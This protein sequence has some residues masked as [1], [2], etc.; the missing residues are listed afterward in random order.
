MSEPTKEATAYALDEAKQAQKRHGLTDL[1]T[2]MYMEAA[3]LGYMQGIAAAQPEP[4]A[5]DE[6][7]MLR[8]NGMREAAEIA[9]NFRPKS[10][11]TC[12]G[13]ISFHN[14]IPGHQPGCLV[15]ECLEIAD[16]IDARADEID[17]TPDRWLAELDAAETRK[18]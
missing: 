13:Y 18:P 1:A 12:G 15:G 5:Q 3:E 4:A 14:G 9:R 10:A 7:P 8:S 6:M 11:C 2:A 17:E 16:E